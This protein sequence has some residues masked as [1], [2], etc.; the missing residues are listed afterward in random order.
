MGF[1]TPLP[2]LLGGCFFA[3]LSALGA[4]AVAVEAAGFF[5]AAADAA[6]GIVAAGLLF[7]LMLPLPLADDL[8]DSAELFCGWRSVGDPFF[9]S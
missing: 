3:A 4:A 7:F 1:K 6:A 5:S 8:D 2:L 9:N